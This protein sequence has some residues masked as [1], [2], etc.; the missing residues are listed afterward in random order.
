MANDTS[1]SQMR[2][3]VAAEVKNILSQMLDFANASFNERYLFAG[4]ATTVAPFESQVEDSRNGGEGFIYKGNLDELPREIGPKQMVAAN[5]ILSDK[6]VN[7]LNNVKAFE[8]SLVENDVEGIRN[9]IDTLGDGLN[10]VNQARTDAGAR[11]ARIEMSKDLLLNQKNQIAS[12][13]SDVE[14]VDIAEVMTRFIEEQ[15]SYRMALEVAAK[16]VQP[17]LID[18]FN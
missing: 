16:I 15:N 11:T 4:S 8:K 1:D 14:D 2:E 9:Q 6:M 7:I 12:L 5:V 18:F 17:T 13:L 10:Q 3:N